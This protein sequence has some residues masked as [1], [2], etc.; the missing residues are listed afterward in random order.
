M[1]KVVQNINSTDSRPWIY[2]DD[3]KIVALVTNGDRELADKF[4]AADAMYDAI[5]VALEALEAEGAAC[6]ERGEIYPHHLDDAETELREA[7]TAA[8]GREA[9]DG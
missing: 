7:L 9:R 5:R 8:E 1:L 3:G 2:D 4:A 6:V